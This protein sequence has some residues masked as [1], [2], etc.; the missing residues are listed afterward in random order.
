MGQIL[1]D[2]NDRKYRIINFALNEVIPQ[3]GEKKN[4]DC[5]IET[6]IKMDRLTH[7]KTPKPKETIFFF[8]FRDFGELDSAILIILKCESLYI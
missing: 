7:K 1:N 6:E 4:P 2:A 5:V 3:K 8:Y